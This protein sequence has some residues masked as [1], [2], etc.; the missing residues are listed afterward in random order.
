MYEEIIRGILLG[1]FY[2][3]QAA[4]YGYLASEEL[5]V[6]WKAILTTKFWTTFSWTKASKT[7]L[8]GITLGAISSGYGFIRPEDWAIFTNYTGLPQISL[9]LLLNFANTAVVMGADKFIKFIV[10]RTP[11][12]RAWNWLKDRVLK[13]LLTRD[14]IAEIISEETKT[15]AESPQ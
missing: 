4:L 2:G 3:G 13:L 5:P 15:P 9:P 14:K 7:V 12:V 10:R 11:L 8:L 1:A 6:S